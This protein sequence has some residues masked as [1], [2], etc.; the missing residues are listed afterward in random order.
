MD[1]PRGD[2]RASYWATNTTGGSLLKPTVVL[3]RELSQQP[4]KPWC[5]CISSRS[6]LSTTRRQGSATH[7]FCRWRAEAKSNLPQ[8]GSKFAR[9]RA[10]PSSLHLPTAKAWLSKVAALPKCSRINHSDNTRG[11]CLFHTNAIFQAS[12]STF[13]VYFLN[14]TSIGLYL[15]KFS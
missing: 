11:M 4:A 6:T 5:L 14:T 8:H 9:Q 1:I 15:F 7:G 12:V 2:R 3:T 10:E 13:E